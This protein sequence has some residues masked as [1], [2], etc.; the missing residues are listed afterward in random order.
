MVKCG[1]ADNLACY[2]QPG[3]EIKGGVKS[4]SLKDILIEIY[5]TI[6]YIGETITYDIYG[7]S[8]ICA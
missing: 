8:Y 7:Y 2:Y 1:C 4:Q 5:Y 6:D 3:M